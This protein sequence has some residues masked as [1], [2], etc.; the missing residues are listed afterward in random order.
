MATYPP[1]GGW[2]SNPDSIAS[3]TDS[4]Q[5]AILR[6]ARRHA[7]L[8]AVSIGGGKP[9]TFG[10]LIRRAFAATRLVARHSVQR[11]VPV[12]LC[13][14]KGPELVS[15]VLGVL[16][17]GGTYVCC[18]PA[19]SEGGVTEWL[20]GLGVRLV[21]GSGVPPAWLAALPGHEWLDI[22][23]WPNKIPR[24]PFFGAPPEG[25]GGTV[26]RT[27][28]TTGLPRGVLLESY[29][30]LHHAE[31]MAEAE[32][33]DVTSRLSWL[34]PP[35]VAAAQSHLFAALLRGACL[36]P[37][38]PAR[39]GLR[40]MTAW[41]RRERVSHLHATP[42]LIRAWLRSL[43]E[44]ASFPDL[45]CIK[46]G[47][48]PA[49]AADVQLMRRHLATMPRVINGL[50]MSEAS[51]NIAC[52]E[53]TAEDADS[54][55]LLPVGYP[56]AGRSVTLE[57][58]RGRAVG[59]GQ[60]GEIVVQ[61]PWVASGYSPPWPEGRISGHEANRTLRT[62]DVGRWDSGGRLVHLGRIDDRIRIRGMTV[63]LADVEARVAS[64]PTVAQVTV[65]PEDGR[66]GYRLA[67]VLD[68]DS[69]TARGSLI[70]LLQTILPVR[71]RRVGFFPD[72]PFTARGKRDTGEIRRSWP[73][74]A[75]SVGWSDKEE[76]IRS[77]WTEALGHDCFGLDDPFTRVG[78]D[79]LAVM[80][81]VA[82]LSRINGRDLDVVEVI[83]F[84]TVRAQA[85]RLDEGGFG[86]AYSP[87]LAGSVDFRIDWVRVRG[88]SAAHAI[89]CLPGGWTTDAEMWLG[90]A[91]LQDVDP[92]RLC[93]VA[94]TN[95]LDPLVGG[96]RSL[97]E[98][99][100]PLLPPL[101]GLDQLTLVGNCVGV[102]AI[103]E[104]AV[105]LTTAGRRAPRVVLLDP[106]MP[107]SVSSQ[108]EVP[109]NV[110]RFYV[111]LRR[112]ELPPPPGTVD[113]VLAADDPRFRH[114]QAFWTAWAGDPARVHASPG[115]HNSF[116]REHRHRVARLLADI[117]AVTAHKHPTDQ[118]D[119]RNGPRD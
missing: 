110:S 46:L 95:L 91:L 59:P 24:P 68:D 105:R 16:F 69:T 34:A 71:P 70:A 63:D 31:L 102:T 6:V 51:G 23:R 60:T 92:D 111:V 86:D 115:D 45:A 98:I 25:G 106:W 100:M 7:H 32:R 37:F 15:H 90:A 82:D 41:L 30:M 66:E 99:V 40:E 118:C 64:L 11:E 61:D 89:A 49:H 58:E 104:L 80:S 117:S 74:P 116:I 48:E 26:V 83:R 101:L 77:C 44:A 28:G 93:L 12:A 3:M 36:C 76:T 78:G 112:D 56:V 84:D 62:G 79:S 103:L 96:P 18:D 38:E 2:C 57:D 65:I 87:T 20:A 14:P 35:G 113:I 10:R 108:S 97:D 4:L 88:R 72:L 29:S 19:A 13:M 53:I 22:S 1:C 81:L 42:S 114:R 119:A 9:V 85:R 54:G 109:A 5:Q 94:R 47:G 43:P 107:G 17:A 73:T 75:S 50:G 27:S 21:M 52:G 55:G 39:G 33:I 8:P 67:L